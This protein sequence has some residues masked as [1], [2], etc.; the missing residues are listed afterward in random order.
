MG[1]ESVKLALDPLFKFVERVS[2]VLQVVSQLRH[3]KGVK[4]EDVARLLRAPL[5]NQADVGVNEFIVEP[6]AGL[7]QVKRLV[8]DCISCVSDQLLLSLGRWRGKNLSMPRL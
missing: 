1:I 7:K 3:E 6:Y 2:P 5:I 4:A 8:R